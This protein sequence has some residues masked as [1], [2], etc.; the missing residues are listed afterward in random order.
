MPHTRAGTCLSLEWLASLRSQ[1]LNNT[2]QASTTADEVELELLDVVAASIEP[3]LGGALM[4]RLATAAPLAALQHVKRVRKST[5]LPGKLDIVLW[6]AYPSSTNGGGSSDRGGGDRY[7]SEG[8]VLEEVATGNDTA[9]VADGELQ[10]QLPQ[11]VASL[12]QEHGLELFI[13]QV[14]AW[15]YHEN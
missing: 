2:L 14:R 7:S 8:G 3:K 1:V 15:E 13:G 10:S 6:P 12:V 11:E 4:K 5:R 9:A